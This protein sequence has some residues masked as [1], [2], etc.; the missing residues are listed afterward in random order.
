[1]E[2][3]EDYKQHKRTVPLCLSLVNKMLVHNDV[4]SVIASDGTVSSRT[5]FGNYISMGDDTFINLSWKKEKRDNW[6][7]IKY[8][9]NDN[10][11]LEWKKLG[12]KFNITSVLEKAGIR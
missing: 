2:S 4:N 11:E 12:K 7:F 10:G 8:T 3:Y 9:K 6:G 1:M 5:L